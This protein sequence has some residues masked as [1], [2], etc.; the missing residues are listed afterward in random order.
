MDPLEVSQGCIS[1]ISGL[2][3]LIQTWKGKDEYLMSVREFLNSLGSTIEKYTNSNF[4]N[5]NQLAFIG[6]KKQLDAFE[7]Y[8]KKEKAKNSIVKFFKG[9]TFIDECDKYID[10][11]QKWLMTMNL[12]AAMHFNE[13]TGN[14]F[15]ELYGILKKMEETRGKSRCSFKDE[16]QNSK[17][18]AF[19]IKVQFAF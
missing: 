10:E 2:I 16:F 18:A 6:L 19:W 12:D 7:A 15:Q 5:K 4:N 17:A 9:N 1:I 8:L 3:S 13:E 14:N 11:F